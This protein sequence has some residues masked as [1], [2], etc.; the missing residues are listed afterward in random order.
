PGLSKKEKQRR[1]H[2]A[3]IDKLASTVSPYSKA[4]RRRF[5]KRMREQ[6]GGGMADIDLAL[7]ALQEKDPYPESA[8][9]PDSA[10]QSSTAKQTA[11]SRIGKNKGVPLTKNQR[12]RALEIESLRHPLILS[13]RRF[14]D[15]PFETIRIHAQNTL[16]KK[17]LE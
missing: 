1:K 4:Q 7:S 13:D 2:E 11:T 12:K 16:E 8:K 17:V 14:A 10:A 9:N 5:N 3:F 6:V 15:N